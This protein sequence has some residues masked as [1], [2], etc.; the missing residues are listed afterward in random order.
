[1]A[2]VGAIVAAIGIGI[3]IFVCRQRRK[4]IAIRELSPSHTETK[5]IL[6]TVSNYQVNNQVNSG[7]SNFTS[8]IPSY[9]SSKTSNDFGKS[10]YFG[11][12][13][14]SYEELEVATDNFNNSREL[15][16][17]GFG[18]V[19]YGNALNPYLN[20]N[21]NKKIINTIFDGGYF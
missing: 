14:F 6:T 17:G 3:G 19:Y 13:V 1:M 7:N 10:S 2:V 15:G 18:A 11:A 21:L 8:S 5:A 9:P 20:I 16:D 4:R 12:Q